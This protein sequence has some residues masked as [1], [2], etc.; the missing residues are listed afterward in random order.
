MEQGRN[1]QV[2]PRT[3]ANYEFSV[4]TKVKSGREAAVRKY[5][6]TI[7]NLVAENPE[8]LA[9]LKLHYLRWVLFEIKDDT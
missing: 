4:M 9:P 8:V 1:G 7:E 6:N 2:Y 5:G 3:P